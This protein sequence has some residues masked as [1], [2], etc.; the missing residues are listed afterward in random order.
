MKS[1]TDTHASLRCMWERDTRV[2]A[3]RVRLLPRSD[4]PGFSAG[5]RLRRR[6]GWRGFWRV[7]LQQAQHLLRLQ[8]RLVGAAAVQQRR[9]GADARAH[10]RALAAALRAPRRCLCVD[11]GALP[12]VPLSRACGTEQHSLTPGRPP[13]Q[14]VSAAFRV[15]LGLHRAGGESGLR[16]RAAMAAAGAGRVQAEGAP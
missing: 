9:A 7:L 6:A 1:C 4:A 8:L 10:A 15:G 16:G 5:L 2:C 11:C 13:P 12:R 14:R 3:V